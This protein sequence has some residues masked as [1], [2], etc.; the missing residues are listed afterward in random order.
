M[1]SFAENYEIWKPVYRF[2]N[3]YEVSSLGRIK[4][5]GS[6]RVRKVNYAQVYPTIM[7]SVD[8]KHTTLRVHRIVAIAFCPNYKEG[9]H[10]N[11]IDGNKKNFLPLNLE[12]TSQAENNLHSYRSLK[13]ES[14]FKGKTPWNKKLKDPESIKLMY[15]QNI[16]GITTDDI[17]KEYGVCGSTIRKHLREYRK[18]L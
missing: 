11:H 1:I 17:G 16:S 3:Y 15:L 5:K 8:K 10:V 13:R 14:Y 6:K 4:R 7:L 9:N 18:S 12:W 2:E